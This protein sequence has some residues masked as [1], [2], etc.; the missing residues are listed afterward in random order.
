[1]PERNWVTIREASELTGRSRAAIATMVQR[2][3]I[4][5]EKSGETWLI[6]L[7]ALMDYLEYAE[8]VRAAGNPNVARKMGGP[9]IFLGHGRKVKY[10]RRMQYDASW[11]E[12]L[13]EEQWQTNGE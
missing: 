12:H 7:P 9:F 10:N 13:E 6:Y 2:C 3:Q 4:R 1:M 5:A 8:Q 11:W